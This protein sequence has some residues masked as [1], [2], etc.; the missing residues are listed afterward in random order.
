MFH[1]LP[2]VTKFKLLITACMAILP[3]I[4][5][6]TIIISFLTQSLPFCLEFLCAY[7]EFWAIGNLL[8]GD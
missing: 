6:S 4:F 7:M 1:C 3:L 5:P 8:V 2:L